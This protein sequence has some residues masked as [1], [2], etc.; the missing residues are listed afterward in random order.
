MKASMMTGG[1][2]KSKGANKRAEI[3]RKIMKERGVSMIE[4]SK[5]VKKEN[6]YK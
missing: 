5:I 2:K 4:A 1:K 6:L 3:V